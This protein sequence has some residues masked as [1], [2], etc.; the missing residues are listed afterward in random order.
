[1]DERIVKFISALRS[2]GVRIS[3]AESADAF[4]AV[5]QMGIWDRDTFRLSLQT[6]LVK[7]AR[8]LPIFEELFPLFFGNTSAPPLMN[9]SEDLTPE[10]AQKIAEGLRQFSEQIRKMLERLLRGDQLSPEELDRLGKFVG[11][12]QID[13]LR[14]REWMSQRLQKALRFPE[15]RE[16][17][18]ELAELLAQMGMDKQRVDQMMRLMQANQQALEEQLHQFAGQRIADNLSEQRPDDN[19]DALLNRPFSSLSDKDMDKLRKQV[20]RL[21]SILRTRVALRQK[22][23]KSG[24]LDAK[25][26]IRANLKHGSVPIEIKHREHSLKP[27]LVVVCDVS[28]SMRSCS[29]LMLSLLYALQDQISKTHAFAFIDHLEYISP[30]FEG[31][32]AREAVS[33]VLDRMPSGYYNTDFGNSLENFNQDYL[34]TMDGRTTFLVVGDGRNNYNDPRV[35]IFNLLARRSNRTI[36]ITPEA[37]GLWGTGDS[38]MLKY[39]PCC[40]FVLQA[41]NLAELTLAVDKLLSRRA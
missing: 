15:V 27:K 16:A 28:T 18:Q 20:Q 14:Y 25:K 40:D 21:A 41:S 30:A 17:L 9:L 39:A 38:D 23:A 24:Q 29:E 4:S 36:W 34:D 31:Y 37:S 26:T 7:D 13:D 2:A 32:E 33:Q 19:I 6:T 22:R 10:E 12:N 11:L 5:D 35:D 1:M 3:L 8:N